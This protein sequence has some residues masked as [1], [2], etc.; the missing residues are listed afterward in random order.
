MNIK[1]N[2]LVR[3]KYPSSIREAQLIF[4]VLEVRETRIL[5][6][7]YTHGG[8]VHSDYYVAPTFVYHV[9]DLESVTED[10]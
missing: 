9:N 6:T 7:E 5:V 2:D 1:E 8:I 4:R 3:F 10:M